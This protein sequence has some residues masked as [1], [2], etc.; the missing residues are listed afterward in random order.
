MIR[1]A[2]LSDACAIVDIYNY[3]ILNT[4]ITFEIKA[5][6]A[7]EMQRR[8]LEFSANHP[9]LV[10]E[11]DGRIV[12]YA[13]AH[14]W[15]LREAYAHTVESTVYLRHDFIGRGIGS[16]LL[17]TLIGELRDTG[18]HSVI[19]CITTPNPKSEHLHKKLGFRQVSKFHE[20]GRKFEHWIGVSDWQLIL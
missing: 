18:I 8:I 19:A 14:Q 1:N 10:Y 13:Y 6:S 17:S 15:K 9:F 20:V 3:Y 5:I 7:D 12:G 2:V 4:T 11:L 16:S